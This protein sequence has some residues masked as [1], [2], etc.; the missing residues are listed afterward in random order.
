MQIKVVYSP[1]LMRKNYLIND[2][3]SKF[4]SHKKNEDY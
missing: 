1:K 4:S 2:Y 3:S